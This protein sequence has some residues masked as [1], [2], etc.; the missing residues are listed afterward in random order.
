MIKNI[1]VTPSG[2]EVF[3]V[4]DGYQVCWF[5][6]GRGVAANWE[7]NMDSCPD[8]HGEGIEKDI[9]QWGKCIYC[10]VATT[11][12]SHGYWTCCDCEK[13]VYGSNEPIPNDPARYKADLFQW[14]GVEVQ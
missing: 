13:Q 3:F 12:K 2:V 14:A 5:C 9:M 1:I 6:N 11:L 7:G 10:T 4:P 8:C